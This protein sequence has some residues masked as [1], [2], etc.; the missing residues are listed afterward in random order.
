MPYRVEYQMFPH[1]DCGHAPSPTRGAPPG[2]GGFVPIGRPIKVV[3]DEEFSGD[4][5]GWFS[6]RDGAVESIEL[7]F[8]ISEVEYERLARCAG[9]IRS[10]ESSFS[11]ILMRENWQALT[12]L[13][14]T[15]EGIRYR[16]GKHAPVSTEREA[17]SLESSVGSIQFLELCEDVH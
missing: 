13:V 15:L 6:A 9:C 2:G 10:A 14:Q 4:F 11:F 12:G 1:T 3:R 17:A 5:I 7:R 8:D 16:E